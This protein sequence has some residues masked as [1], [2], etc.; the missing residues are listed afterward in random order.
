M[1]DPDRIILLTGASG[2][3]GRALLDTLESEGWRVRCMVRRPG[4]LQDQVAPGTEIVAGDVLD[5]SSL[6]P[7]LQG[8]DTAFYLVHSMSS[9]GEFEQ[10][11]RLAAMNFAAAAR[12]SGVRRIIYLGGLGESSSRLSAHL[13]SRHE[14]GEI[15]RSSGVQTL[16]FRSSI[17]VGCGGFS[18]EM[19]R[20]L[21]ERLPVMVTP[22]WVATPTQPIAISDLI[23]YLMAGLKIEVDGNRI[24]E[25]GGKDVSS[26][27]DL[28]RKYARQRGLHRLMIPVPVLTPRL[29]SLWLALVT[30]YYSRV[31]R[32]LVDGLQNPTV[33]RE[34]PDPA[35]ADIR[36]L[37]LRAAV[38][39]ALNDED[40]EFS[41]ASWPRLLERRKV[42]PGRGAIRTGTRIIDTRVVRVAVPADV[43]FQVLERIGGN[44]GWYYADWLWQARGILDRLVGG[45]GM[46]RGRRDPLH[47]EEGDVL[48]FWR[49]ET[50]ERPSRLRLAAE[51]KVPGRA[52]LEFQVTRQGE[53]SMLRQT[54]M[55]DALGLWGLA[56]WFLLYPVHAL[57]FAGML[58]NI[59][60]AASKPIARQ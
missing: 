54:A 46:R 38:A 21:V 47:L 43:V 17:V 37:G 25:I 30:P 28:M 26:Y 18:F 53:E 39:K 22:R 49:V 58:R 51:M 19:I 52:W 36:P 10:E 27:G 40:L 59:V 11:D 7:A 1:N 42:R 31:G 13:R 45:V 16:E 14:V 33:V 34:A 23:L 57:I 2:Y 32:K 9:P 41:S 48:D 24:Y 20:S 5:A 15:L 44:T 4:M 60:R 50:L 8:V 35:L 55:F 29:S 12:A 56:Y 6:R 3:V